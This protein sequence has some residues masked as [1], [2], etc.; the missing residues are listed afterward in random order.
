MLSRIPAL[1]LAESYERGEQYE[2]SAALLRAAEAVL[3]AELAVMVRNDLDAFQDIGLE[4]LG[5]RAGKLRTRYAKV[6]HPGAREIVA[7]LDG[8]YRFAGEMH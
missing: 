1:T 8:A 7:W 4:Q 6:D 2:Y 5:D 3:G